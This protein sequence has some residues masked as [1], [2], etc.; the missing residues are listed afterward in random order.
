[1]MSFDGFDGL[2][3]A[4]FESCGDAQL[5]YSPGR[6]QVL[7]ANA[8]AQ[9]LSGF[10][11]WELRAT[12]PAELIRPQL[13]DG[14]PT[15]PAGP[16]VGTLAN[17]LLRTFASRYCLVDVTLTRLCVRPGPLYLVTLRPAAR[18]RRPRSPGFGRPGQ[19]LGVARDESSRRQ[20]I[21]RPRRPATRQL[22]TGRRGC[23]PGGGTVGGGMVS[24]PASKL[25]EPAEGLEG[26]RSSL[27]DPGPD[28][29]GP[30]ERDPDRGL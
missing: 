22:S 15:G 26:K 27:D 12:P 20:G 16:A 7:D 11:L 3:Q 24:R 25:I 17:C 18:G 14:L 30:V 1:M 13:G 28:R 21:G 23:G 29:S 2:A 4:L 19:V 9:R 6:G 5:L 8:A 10:N